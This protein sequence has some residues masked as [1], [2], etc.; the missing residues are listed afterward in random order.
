GK[1]LSVKQ[2]LRLAI[3]VAKGLAAAHEKGFVHRD[4]KP[5][6]IWIEPVDGGRAK[7]LDFGL[8]RAAAATDQQITQS[9]AVVGTPAYMAP[10][11]ARGD[12][13]DHRC[14]LFSLGGVLYRV[15]TGD[16]PFRGTDTIATLMALA[17]KDPTP[18]HLVNDKVP[19]ELSAYVMRLL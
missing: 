2:M 15:F 16:L 9:G 8:A 11:Q 13:V 14:D 3:H 7:I 17:L 18:P 6:N 4:I 19:H 5:D 1:T 10:E 12:Q